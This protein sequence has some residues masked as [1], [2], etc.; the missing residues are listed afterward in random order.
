M[1]SA[2]LVAHIIYRLGVGGLENGLVNLINKTPPS[3]YRHIIICLKD[4][5]G[6]ANRIQPP[7][8]IYCLNRQEGQ[9]YGMFLRLYKLL[10]ELRPDI[11]H[12]RNL[13]TVECQLPAWMAGVPC[14]VH[15]EHGWDVFDPN[16]ENRKY[17]WLRRVF[18]IL[19]H[20]YIPLS[21]HL[22]RYLLDQ[23]H[24]PAKKIRRIC[25]GVDTRIFYPQ[26]KAKKQVL[27]CP[28][29]SD[30]NLLWIGAVGRMHGVKDQTTLAKAFLKL[31]KRRPQ[32][33]EQAR[34]LLIGEGPL[35][36]EAQ[37]LLQA[38][39]ALD[40]AW[41]PGERN[42]IAEI[43]GALDLFVLPSLAEGI[44]N[45]ILEAMASGL[46][47]VA[48][49]VGGNPDLVLDGETGRLIEPGNPEAMA[50]ALA[51]YL[52]HPSLLAKHGAAG[53][54]RVQECFSLDKMV[55]GYLGVYD[56]LLAS[57]KRAA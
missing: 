28:F 43:M 9:D 32:T 26:P 23:V 37:R 7:I 54:R 6:F 55:E 34:L 17:Q 50:E 1:S 10:R 2:P 39:D 4:A 25:N 52:E 12:T 33:R 8:S 22:E 38:G 13:A 42:D 48:A 24:I 31:L 41:M 20:R 45:T 29:S 46:P 16:G 18:Q 35:R 40:L 14:R 44:S 51:E 30:E 47:V 21:R 19:V 11:V 3:R 56:E 27:D 57:A 36:A 53:L 15:G 49:R 5:D